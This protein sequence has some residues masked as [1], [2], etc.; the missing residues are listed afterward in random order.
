MSILGVGVGAD[1]GG[2]TEDTGRGGVGA[3]E[4]GGV[5][6]D[7]VAKE[8]AIA[9]GASEAKRGGAGDSAG[10]AGVMGFGA[11]AGKEEETGGG[12][13]VNAGVEGGGVGVGVGAKVTFLSNQLGCLTGSAGVGTGA[14]ANANAWGGGDGWAGFPNDAVNAE[15]EVEGVELMFG[16]LN[17]GACLKDVTGADDLV[18]VVEDDARTPCLPLT[19]S[20]SERPFRFSVIAFQRRVYGAS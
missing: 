12:A 16:R 19:I 17:E 3:G 1:M 18:V 9:G 8:G 6:G 5:V 11:G 13:N 14:G 15:P 10:G 4:T 2:A 7:L 20:T